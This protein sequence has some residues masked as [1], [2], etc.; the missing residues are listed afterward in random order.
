VFRELYRYSGKLQGAEVEAEGALTC[1][2]LSTVAR[3]QWRT[4]ARSGGD[5]ITRKKEGDA[6]EVCHSLGQFF[7]EEGGKGLT[8]Q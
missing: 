4:A 7:K 8:G 3:L 1:L 6:N 2:C 5:P